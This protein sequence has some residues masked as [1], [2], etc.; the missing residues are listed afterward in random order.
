MPIV[1][2]TLDCLRGTSAMSYCVVSFMENSL[3]LPQDLFIP[4]LGYLSNLIIGKSALG[5]I[6]LVPVWCR[7]TRF[8]FENPLC[9]EVSRPSCGRRTRN[10]PIAAVLNWPKVSAKYHQILQ[11]WYT[12]GLPDFFVRWS[13]SVAQLFLRS[14]SRGRGCGEVGSVVCFPLLHTLF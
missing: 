6:F 14:S 1:S 7:L 11:G 10:P 13:V 9:P 12:S 2:S 3:L 4:F 8:A 5:I